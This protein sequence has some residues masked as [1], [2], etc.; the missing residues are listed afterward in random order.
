M[1]KLIS[2]HKQ[3]HQKIVALHK[4]AH[5]SRVMKTL[6]SLKK[7]SKGFGGAVWWMISSEPNLDWR[8]NL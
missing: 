3:K 2:T 7:K 8:E 4:K 5:N 1:K 6:K